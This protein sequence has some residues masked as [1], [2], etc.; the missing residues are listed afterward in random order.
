MTR[1]KSKKHMKELSERFRTI[2][3]TKGIGR[4]ESITIDFLKKL[5]D[6]YRVYSYEFKHREEAHNGC[7]WLWI[8]ITN[9]GAFYFAVQA[10]KLH[11]KCLRRNQVL[12]K[13]N[14]HHLPQINRLLDYSSKVKGIPIYVLYSNRINF[15]NGCKAG[16]TTKE[17]I[18]WDYAPHVY[19]LCNKRILRKEKPFPISC[20]FTVF[21]C[22]CSYLTKDDDRN[23]HLCES[24]SICK[25]SC[26]CNRNTETICSNPFRYFFSHFYYASITD[27]HKISD[28]LL[29]MLF[30]SKMIRDSDAYKSYCINGLLGLTD[31]LTQRIII[32][33]YMQKHDKDYASTLM[34]S[35]FQLDCKS[36]LER[37]SIESRLRK[38]IGEYGIFKSFGIFGSYAHPGE[39][40][41][42]GRTKPDE[43]S[44]IDI[45][46]SY[47]QAKFRTPEDL[48][49]IP[50]FIKATINEFKK[51]V[52]FIDYDSCD[53]GFRKRI[54][55]KIIWIIQDKKNK[56]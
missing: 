32:Q 29:I 31:P 13:S 12:Y 42:N 53:K 56:K 41:E 21:S 26:T 54:D 2:F 37:S 34:G 52:D 20:L 47:D 3:D 23:Y 5:M 51:N 22:H 8:I 7:D 55:E 44:D 35:D 28:Y 38:I 17:G 9:Q 19:N 46:F 1:D 24:C 45:V 33:D 16:K 43:F 27:P 50:R 30:A 18:F 6:N 36:V 14:Q 39:Q 15:I 49:M 40:R 48:R 25:S 10:K 4:E 11:S